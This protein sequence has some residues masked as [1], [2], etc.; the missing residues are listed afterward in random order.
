MQEAQARAT[1]VAQ[2]QQELQRQQ[3][4]GAWLHTAS[5]DTQRAVVPLMADQLLREFIEVRVCVCVC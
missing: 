4:L 2:E 3:E 5:F 1:R